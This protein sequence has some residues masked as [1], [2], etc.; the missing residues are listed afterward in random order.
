MKFENS[1]AGLMLDAKRL[2]IFGD[3][4]AAADAYYKAHRHVLYSLMLSASC[5]LARAAQEGR[6]RCFRLM[7]STGTKGTDE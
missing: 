7:A 4:R 2:E 5:D 3:F 6:S 1:F